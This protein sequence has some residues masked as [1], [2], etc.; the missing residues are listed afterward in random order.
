MT[1]WASTAAPGS[2]AGPAT[3]PSP[4]AVPVAVAVAVGTPRP[5]GLDPIDAPRRALDAGLAAAPVGS[6]VGGI[7]HAVDS[8]ARAAS[9]G[10]P[11]DFRGHGVG[12]RIRED[13]RVPGRGRSGRGFP[14]LTARAQAGPGSSG[15]DWR[16]SG[17]T[18]NLSR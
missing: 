13:P 1:R 6:R 12:R 8:V 4:S 7:P 18:Y 11:A 16:P 15:S 9:C 10:T 2:T 17:F 5:G 3:R 14:L